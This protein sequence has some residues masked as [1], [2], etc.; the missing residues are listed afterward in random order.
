MKVTGVYLIQLR[1]SPDFMTE[2]QRCES[3]E[4]VPLEFSRLSV[5]SNNLCSFSRLG[6][7]Q[8][9]SSKLRWIRDVEEPLPRHNT[10]SE[11]T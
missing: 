4:N 9:C 3:W 8:L 7:M 2:L 1:R 5:D 10:E 6:F 11:N